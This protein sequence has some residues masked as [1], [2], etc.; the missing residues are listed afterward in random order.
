MS[1]QSNVEDA[2]YNRE[3]AMFET[4]E[5]LDPQFDALVERFDQ[6]S[7]N[8]D[9]EAPF[10]EPLAEVGSGFVRAALNFEGSS[11]ILDYEPNS[12]QVILNT[13]FTQVTPKGAPAFNVAGGVFQF[14]NVF[15]RGGITVIGTGTNPMIWQ[16]TENFVVDGTLL[17][18]GGNGDR[19]NTL[20]SANFPTPGGVGNC[21][22]GNGGKGSP[23]TS[24]Q[25]PR[26]ESGFGPGQAPNGGGA[27]GQI[28]TNTACNRGSGGGGGSFSTAGDPHFKVKAGSN[29][30]FIQQ[31]G[32]GGF[33]CLGVSGASTRTLAGG[34]PGPL[35]FRDARE[36]NN[37][38]GVGVDLQRLIRITGELAAPRG[39]GGGGGGGDRSNQ[40]GNPN[41]IADNKGGGGGA[42][43]GVLII[44]ALDTIRIGPAGIISAD[45]GHGG[46]G[47]QA[48]GN[49]QGGGG[50]GGSGGMVVLI[51]GN[52][53]EITKHGETYANNDFNF[54]ISADGGVGTQG[55][56]GGNEWLAKYP[57]PTQ[58]SEWDDN[59]SGGFG[60]MGLVQLMAPPGDNSD[61]TNTR[62][63]D[64]IVILNS[65]GLPETD[66][67]EKMRYLA[68]RGFFIN[69]QWVDDDNNP[70]YA[71]TSPDDEGDIRPAPILLPSPISPTSRVRSIWI[72]TG[73]SVRRPLSQFG[74]GPRSIRE[75][76]EFNAGPEYFFAGANAE[77]DPGQPRF[78]WQGYLDYVQ[79]P[80]GVELVA[81]PVLPAPVAVATV[82]DATF[83]GVP[84][85]EVR[86][87]DRVLGSIRDR[88]AQYQAQL[89]D[90][91]G[92]VLGEY[93]VLGHDDQTL[94]LSP[95]QGAL[96][97]NT[98]SLRL[99]LVAKFIDVRTAGAR[100]L[101]P[102]YTR[103]V[104]QT[105]TNVPVANIRLGFAF[106]RNPNENSPTRGQDCDRFP[107]EVGTFLYDLSDP[108]V[109]E[110]IRTFTGCGTTPTPGAPFVMWDMLFNLRFSEHEVNN[111]AAGTQ[112][113]PASPRPEV[114]LLVIPYRF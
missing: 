113:S 90:T 78:N 42:G 16:A 99:Q 87:A 70:T 57:P 69:G 1:G 63:D 105:S 14:R 34:A 2:S 111:I 73:K 33:G 40:P 41:W 32:T 89:L 10:L 48:G 47:E 31:V 86:L 85:Y 112:L 74:L 11:T 53:I 27:G 84:S 110:A 6:A 66:P 44:Q 4:K 9:F 62:L 83:E 59:P 103:T 65:S 15:I 94:H 18:D 102:T 36:D 29:N 75:N 43:G 28:S 68:W 91:S 79:T 8:I 98:S 7:N 96:P 12:P 92:N 22:G 20:S 38:W 49:N 67:E 76:G 26:G 80:S 37:Y 114:R 71:N 100:G 106:H 45:G 109:Q 61:G 39:G 95:E 17:V 23:N 13:N 3:V 24:A 51:A 5:A 54:P 104:G 77:T 81:P 35:A 58:P 56:F 97:T 107:P 88:Y 52:R 60:G 82:M 108:S 72:D 101:G 50:G 19:V 55:R 64:N 30:S 46:G 21:N 25:S 93:R